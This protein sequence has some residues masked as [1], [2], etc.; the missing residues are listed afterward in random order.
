MIEG[1]NGIQQRSSTMAPESKQASKQPSINNSNILKKP[2]ESSRRI[3]D[4]DMTDVRTDERSFAGSHTR[5]KQKLNLSN[6]RNR[7]TS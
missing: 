1:A 4:I 2:T 3:S 7:R 6:N 5:T